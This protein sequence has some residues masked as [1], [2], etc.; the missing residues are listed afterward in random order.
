MFFRNLQ[1]SRV[2]VEEARW[3]RTIAWVARTEALPEMERLIRIADRL[4]RT[5][6]AEQRA[7]C[8]ELGLEVTERSMLAGE[9][10]RGPMSV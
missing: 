9:P 5:S 8:E 1:W 2:G 10:R 4:L 6:P 7:V 3:P